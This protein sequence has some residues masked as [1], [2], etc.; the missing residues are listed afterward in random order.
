MSFRGLLLTIAAI[1]VPVASWAQEPPEV[2]Y[3]PVPCT[4]PDKAIALC[5]AVSDDVG[6]AKA[7]IYFRKAGKKYFSFVEMV[8]GGINYCGTLPAPR[9]GKVKSLEYYLQAVDTEYE[10]KRTSTFQ[11]QVQAEG[12]CAFPPVEEDPEKARS[13]VVHATH[14]KQG[15][16]LPKDFIST[17]VTFVPVGR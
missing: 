13:I 12:V 6:V 17:G 9:E 11:M 16:K 15:K 7:R 14:K 1:A 4:V 8:F 10:A 5:A 2:E 3:Q